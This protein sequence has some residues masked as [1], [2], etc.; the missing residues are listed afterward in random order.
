MATAERDYYE[1][2]GVERDGERRRDQEG[3]PEARARAASGRARQDAGRA[4]SAS[5]RSPRRTRC[6][7]TPRRRKLY[8]RYGHAGLRRGGFAPSDFD[9]GEPQRP[10]LRLLRRRPLRR[11]DRGGRARGGDVGAAVAIELADACTRRRSATVDGRGRGHVRALR[12]RRRRARAPSSSPARR[13]GGA[14]PGC[15]RSRGASSASSSA[16]RRARPAAGAGTVVETPV[17]RRAA[18]HGPHDRGDG[19][20]RSR[21]R[22]GSTTASGSASRGEGHAGA[23]RRPS[24]ATST[25]SVHVARDARFVREGD[26]ILSAGRPDDRRRRRAARRLTVPTLEGDARARRSTA[27]TQPGEVRVLR[28]K[29]MPSLQG[30]GRGDHRVLVNV[31]V[32]RRLTDEQ[33]ELLE[34]LRRALR[35]GHLPARRGLLREARRARSAD[36]PAPRLGRPS[37]TRGPRR[38]ARSCSSSSPRASRR[39]SGDGGALEL[40]AY[41]N[42]AGEERIWQAFGGAAASD[43]EEDWEDRWRAVPQAGSRR[44]AVDRPALGGSRIQRCARRRDRPGRAFGTG[45]HPTTQLYLRAAAKARSGEHCSSRLRFRRAL[46][47]GREAR[48]RARARIRLRSPGRRGDRAERRRQ[49]R[50]GRSRAGRFAQGR[51]ASPSTSRSRTSPPRPSLHSGRGSAR[52]ARSPPATSSPTSPSWMA[53]AA[54][55]ASS[56]AAGRRSA[57]PSVDFRL[58]GELLRSFS[59]LQGVPA[60]ARRCASGSSATATTRS[61]EPVTSP[62]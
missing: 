57:R 31:S 52:D 10:L 34:Q 28:G 61:K 33:R 45:G 11:R 41:T 20:S 17:Q 51:P 58:D 38:R 32:P 25:S 13:C 60:D 2:L 47:R 50:H 6:S 3:V 49:R 14:G 62:S 54:S 29:G 37:P 27:G 46:D 5:A 56:R 48:L 15:S 39:S 53:I 19:R 7:R 59:R 22:P 16:P 40:A 44:L 55:A 35:R 42:A 30:S 8:D 4:R 21:S 23:L 12:R 9:F 1:L 18:A 36:A 26:D 43:V 24:P